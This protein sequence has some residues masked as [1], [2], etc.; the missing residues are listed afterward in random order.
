VKIIDNDCAR[1]FFATLNEKR[2]AE[3][4]YDVVTDYGQLMQLVGVRQ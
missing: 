3:V 2:T 4:T 1:K